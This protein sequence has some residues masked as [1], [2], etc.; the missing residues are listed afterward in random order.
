MR[1]SLW[2]NITKRARWMTKM[3]IGIKMASRMKNWKKMMM[4]CIPDSF[5]KKKLNTMK[6]TMTRKRVKEDS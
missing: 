1:T 4:R 6:K 2:M 3:T 5:R